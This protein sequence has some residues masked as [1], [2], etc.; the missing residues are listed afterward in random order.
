M[1]L[2][3]IFASLQSSELVLIF[4]ARL[5]GPLIKDEAFH[6]VARDQRAPFLV[7]NER[8]D[9]VLALWQEAVN[10]RQSNVFGRILKATTHHCSGCNPPNVCMKQNTCLLPFKSKEYFILYFLCCVL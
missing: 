4:S 10:A 5:H 2:E 7:S 3:I 8:G 6:Y 9:Q 1:L